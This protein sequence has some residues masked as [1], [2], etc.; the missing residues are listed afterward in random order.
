MSHNAGSVLDGG[1]GSIKFHQRGMKTGLRNKR[2]RKQRLVLEALARERM[3][4]QRQMEVNE[5]EYLTEYQE[6]TESHD[7]R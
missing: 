4:R 2:K 5:D 7:R 6:Y 3:A 1:K